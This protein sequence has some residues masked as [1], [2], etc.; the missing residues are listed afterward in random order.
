MAPA[1]AIATRNAARDAVT[2]AD[3][4]PIDNTEYSSEDARKFKRTV[5]TAAKNV[6]SKAGG[7]AGAHGHAYLAETD[8]EFHTR[9]GANPSV[10]SNPGRLTY[11]TGVAPEA[12][13]VTM[14]QERDDHEIE[15]EMFY[16]QEGV[17]SG[18]RKVIIDNVPEEILVELADD[19]SGFD[20]VDPRDVI[21]AVMANAT[22]DTTLEAV[23]LIKLRDE[24]LIFDED[25]KLALQFKTKSKHI[26]DLLRVHGIETSDTEFMAK[27]LS[28]I[29]EE[30]GEDFED[31]A[32]K[33]K[34]GTAGT[35]LAEFKA[36]F[37]DRDNVVRDRDRHKR[38]KAK[39]SG[40]HSANSAQE[41]EER[42]ANHLE[43]TL[44]AFAIATEETINQALDKPAGTTDKSAVL[45]ALKEL[46]KEVTALKKKSSQT[47]T[48][49]VRGNGGKDTSGGDGAKKKCKYCDRPHLEKTPEVKCFERPENASEVPEWYKRAKAK[50]EAKEAADS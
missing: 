20:D 13:A 7:R 31:Q 11:A 10:A 24:Q 34:T 38:T 32:A 6:P 44:A 43:N 4:H 17:K 14:A 15:L 29:Q 48:N 9:A 47:T 36:Y 28:G 16:T 37:T 50:R 30:G 49:G 8:A 46:T 33:W 2:N 41:I 35:T 45:E 40:F 18:L 27:M 21:A 22:P 25:T 26:K 23:D 42:I 19:D 3:I 1:S 39:D 12:R 5:L